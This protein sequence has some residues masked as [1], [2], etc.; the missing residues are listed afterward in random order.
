MR[1]ERRAK[2][3]EEVRVSEREMAEVGAEAEVSSLGGKIRMEKFI[4][5]AK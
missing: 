1:E 4:S 3:R 2:W 5:F